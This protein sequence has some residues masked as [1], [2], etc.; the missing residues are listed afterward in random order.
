[1][2]VDTKRRKKSTSGFKQMTGEER[3]R[4]I[5]FSTIAQGKQALDAA[6]LDMGKMLRGKHHAN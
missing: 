6:L 3:A 2:K 4:E 5:L 1:M